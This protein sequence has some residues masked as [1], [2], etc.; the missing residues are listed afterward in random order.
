MENN[1][2]LI[3]L[4]RNYKTIDFTSPDYRTQLRMYV[5]ENNISN[6]HQLEQ[7]LKTLYIDLVN[8]QYSRVSVLQHLKNVL[9]SLDKI[10]QTVNNIKRQHEIRTIWQSIQMISQQQSSQHNE[11]NLLELW[12]Q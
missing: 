4:Y 6:F 7:K 3:D 10:A 11:T 5:Q 1:R 2:K 12:D 8:K 9:Q